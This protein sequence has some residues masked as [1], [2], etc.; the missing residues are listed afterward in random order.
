MSTKLP[1]TTEK[2][3]GLHA[4]SDSDTPESSPSPENSDNCESQSA[5]TP[6]L[7]YLR[8]FFTKQAEIMGVTQNTVQV[9]RCNEARIEAEKNPASG[10]W[11]ILG[12]EYENGF[13]GVVNSTLRDTL[14]RKFY[15]HR[16]DHALTANKGQTKGH[17]KL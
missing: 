6:E 16:H 12:H 10:Q 4:G 7:P 2:S 5:S 14:K 3:G 1:A 11:R 15:V 13:A 9:H 17:L 8:S